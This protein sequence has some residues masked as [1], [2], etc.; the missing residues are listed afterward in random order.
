MKFRKELDG[1]IAEVK[2]TIDIFSK[3]DDCGI[4]EVKKERGILKHT[5]YFLDKCVEV[6]KKYPDE[7]KIGK[8]FTASLSYKFHTFSVSVSLDD[9]LESQLYNKY[10]SSHSDIY[11]Y[12]KEMFFK[13]IEHLLDT[14]N[15]KAEA[16]FGDINMDE[17]YVQD[18]TR[19]KIDIAVNG[20]DY[21][22]KEITA[23]SKD[24]NFTDMLDNIT[25]TYT[26]YLMSLSDE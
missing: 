17:W 20:V 2:K 8:H 24:K 16:C 10:Y 13:L 9:D 6:D 23:L 12:T 26:A 1:D 25:E 15:L 18:E 3:T 19:S 4:W 11:V 21:V 5:E 14:R 22:M 7:I